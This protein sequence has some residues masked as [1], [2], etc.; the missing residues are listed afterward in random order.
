LQMKKEDLLYL[1]LILFHAALG[2][3]VYLF[4]FVSKIYGYAILIIG[5]YYIIKKQNKNEEALIVAAYVVGSEI[6]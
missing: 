2:F 4:P 1:N 3:L 5:A 6:V